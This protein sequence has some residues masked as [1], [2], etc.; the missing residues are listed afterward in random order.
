MFVAL[1]GLATACEDDDVVA[2]YSATLSDDNE[3]NPPVTN[4]PNASGTF[5]AELNKDNVLSYNVTFTGMTSNVASGHIHGPATVDQAV[6]VLVDFNAPSLGRTL[7]TGVTTGTAVGTL[8]L[9]NLTTNNPNIDGDS[10]L[11]LLNVGRAY[12]NIHTSNNPQGEIRGQITR[13]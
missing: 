2:Q 10:L 5:T 3:R 9:N 13:Q 6:G 11:V 7:T 8:D 4:A 12:V 1:V